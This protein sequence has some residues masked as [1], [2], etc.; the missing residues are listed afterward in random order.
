MLLTCAVAVAPETCIASTV[1]SKESTWV[2]W[3]L[4]AFSQLPALA[5]SLVTSGRARSFLQIFFSS[6]AVTSLWKFLIVSAAALAS[7]CRPDVETALAQAERPR[8][9]AAAQPSASARRGES[10]PR[11]AERSVGSGIRSQRVRD[12]R[13]RRPHLPVGRPRAVGRLALLVVATKPESRRDAVGRRDEV[14]AERVDQLAD[15]DHRA[16]HGDVDGGH[17]LARVVAHGRGDRVEV[18]GELFVIAGEVR[19]EHLLEL[20]AQRLLGGDRV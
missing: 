17:D 10:S 13:G 5:W 3:S 18:L 20:L 7:P 19:V 1:T 16:R 6:P 8:A 4:I 14:R 15:R 2:S 11:S 9:S 12:G